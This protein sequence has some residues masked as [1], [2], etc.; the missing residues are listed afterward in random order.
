MGGDAD[1]VSVLLPKSLAQGYSLGYTNEVKIGMSGS[2]IFN[3]KG[4]LV[5]INGRGKYRDPN[6]GVYAFE[7][8]SDIKFGSIEINITHSFRQGS[9]VSLPR[10]I[11]GK[12]Q[13]RF[14]YI[15]PMYPDL[16]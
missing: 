12:R 8:G 16:I 5:G 9:A 3:A 10:L 1:F 11:V 7:D 4:F 6:F 13:C 14:L 2:P 15:L